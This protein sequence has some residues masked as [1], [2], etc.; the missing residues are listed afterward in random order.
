MTAAQGSSAGALDGELAATK[1]EGDE[2]GRFLS[3]R[4]PKGK[5]Y[6]TDWRA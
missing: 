1:S 4:V 3:K 5:G 2:L 6:A